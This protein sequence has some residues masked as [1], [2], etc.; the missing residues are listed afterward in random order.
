MSYKIQTEFLKI[1]P[2]K[3]TRKVVNGW[4]ISEFHEIMKPVH[5]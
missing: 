3:E 4:A 5:V 2:T 1:L